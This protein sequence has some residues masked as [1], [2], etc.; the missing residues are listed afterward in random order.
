M[1]ALQ[2]MFETFNVSSVY[3]DNQANLFLF[4]ICR[5]KYTAVFSGHGGS[6]AVPFR[7]KHALGHTISQTDITHSGLN[8]NLPHFVM[9]SSH[10]P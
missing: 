3:I 6:H 8:Q 9:D 4:G 1:K 7:Q 5:S 10:F 2:L